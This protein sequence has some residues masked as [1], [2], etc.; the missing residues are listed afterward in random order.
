MLRAIA[1]AL[2]CICGAISSYAQNLRPSGANCTLEAPPATAG[3]ESNHG[4]LLRVFPR[5]K[6]IGRSYTGCQVVL[7]QADSKW[8]LV[9][10]T[11]IVR[12]DPVRIWFESPRSD[13]SLSCRYRAGKVITGESNDCPAAEFLLAKSMARG[14]VAKL[15]QLVAKEGLSGAWPKECTYE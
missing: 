7:A 6:S 11:E 1:L 10:L 14:C 5:A 3:E 13:N 2:L 4:V 9:S 12:G 15:Q 8:Q